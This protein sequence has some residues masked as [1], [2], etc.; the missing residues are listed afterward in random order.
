MIELEPASH[1]GDDAIAKED[2]EAVRLMIDYFYL[3]EY[4]PTL[5]TSASP[6]IAANDIDTDLS[7]E[8]GPQQAE[9]EDGE[10]LETHQGQRDK[11]PG[12]EPVDFAEPAVDQAEK[13]TL[14][15]KKKEKKGKGT[16]KKSSHGD[17]SPVPES[18]VTRTASSPMKGL[19]TMHAKMFNI[20]AKYNIEPLMDVAVMKFRSI[21]SSIWDA[22]DLVTAIPVVYTQTSECDNELR[23]IFE[24][25]ILENAHELISD[26]GFGEAVDHVDGLAW[27][28]FRRLGALSRYQKICRRCGS[29]LDGCRLAPFGGYHNH[30]SCDLK[31]PCRSCI[32]DEQSI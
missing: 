19:L 16:A 15:L 21:A 8:V 24:V 28:L 13:S 7:S 12:P 32:R 18:S 5:I 30:H 22:Q 10:T 25:V 14:S 27:S 20:A 17:S 1:D 29:A 23:D 3:S 4:D 2:P 26:P 9:V 31:G 11:T 6:T